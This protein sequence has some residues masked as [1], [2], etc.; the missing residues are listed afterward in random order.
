LLGYGENSCSKFE[1]TKEE[2]EFS[3]NTPLVEK[4]PKSRAFLVIYG[5]A[6]G[7]SAGGVV[8][9]AGAGAVTSGAAGASITGAGK[10]V[11]F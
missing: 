6:A 9:C 2:T 11:L 10:V 5:F 3:T 8:G 1:R 7:A 4:P